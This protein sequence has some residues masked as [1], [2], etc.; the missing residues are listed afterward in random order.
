MH[1][2]ILGAAACLGQPGQTT[3]FLIGNDTL[4]DCGTGCGSL[5]IEALLALRRVLLTH[6]HIDHCGLLPL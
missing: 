2:T 5:D 3:S 4:L 1:I 6:S